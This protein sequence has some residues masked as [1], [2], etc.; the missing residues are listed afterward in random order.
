MLIEHTPPWVGQQATFS[1]CFWQPFKRSVSGGCDCVGFSG[2]KQSAKH[3][4]SVL[5]PALLKIVRVVRKVPTLPI[6]PLLQPATCR[7]YPLRRRPVEFSPSTATIRLNGRLR[8][9][10]RGR[11]RPMREQGT[12]AQLASSPTQLANRSSTTG[13]SQRLKKTRRACGSIGLHET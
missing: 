5:M 2:R 3:L 12:Q 8:T 1:A 11:L 9:T 4:T 10:P 13:E 6:Q 7:P